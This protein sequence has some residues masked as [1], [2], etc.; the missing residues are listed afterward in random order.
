MEREVDIIITLAPVL[1]Q[2][3]CLTLLKDLLPLNEEINLIFYF[4]LI[5]LPS[6]N[7]A[8]GFLHIALVVTEKIK[9][10]TSSCLQYMNLVWLYIS[11]TSFFW[12][13]LKYSGDFS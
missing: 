5:F 8:S 4:F 2:I 6:E 12:R 1:G 10:F 11:Q 7:I 3:K 9:H 13:Q